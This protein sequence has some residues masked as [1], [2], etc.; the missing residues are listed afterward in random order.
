VKNCLYE[1]LTK[2]ISRDTIENIYTN[3]PKIVGIVS[4]L[5][6]LTENKKHV[7]SILLL[8]NSPKLFLN[9]I[10]EFRPDKI[11]WRS[12]NIDSD[13]NGFYLINPYW[14]KSYSPDPKIKVPIKVRQDDQLVVEIRELTFSQFK[15]SK[16]YEYYFINKI[17]YFYVA[18]YQNFYRMNRPGKYYLA[19]NATVKNYFI[20]QKQLTQIISEFNN[21]KK[22][23]KSE[24]NKFIANHIKHNESLR[25]INELFGKMKIEKELDNVIKFNK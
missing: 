14:V 2:H 17:P 8:E 3:Y 16:I 12:T 22:R 10:V 21:E 25:F 23:I 7:G 13:G 19:I 6:I 18:A 5:D 20:G 11:K 4:N 15:Q 24:W 1:E 9:M